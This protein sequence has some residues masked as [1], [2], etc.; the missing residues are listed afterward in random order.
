KTS[1]VQGIVD[2]T[3]SG[4]AYIKINELDSDVYVSARNLGTALHGDKVK[5]SVFARKKGKIEGEILEILER[6]KTEFV[7]VVE[8]PGKFAFLVPDSPKM[9]VD[10]FI[11]LGKLNGAKHGYKAIAK[12]TDWPKDA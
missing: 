8:V 9:H 6:A 11:P 7:G 3:R 4:A 12:L 10:I 2:M 5:L 1:T